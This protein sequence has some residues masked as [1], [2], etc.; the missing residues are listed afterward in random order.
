VQKKAAKSANH[1]ND[2]VWDTLA[3]RRRIARICAPFKA[4]SGERAL[5]AIG[6]RL[7]APCY[8][9]RDDH[10]RKI[11]ARKQRKDIG[12]HSFVNSTI[13]LWNQ[14]P[15]EALATFPYRSHI[16]KKKVR[17]VIKSEVN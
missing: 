10:D 16:V 3:Q 8:L 14:R 13:K 7:Q 6:D 11:R 15:A 1:A 9:S 12:K 5:K 2:S 17:K 4:Y